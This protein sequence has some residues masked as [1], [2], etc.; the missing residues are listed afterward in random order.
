M[1]VILR[2]A[3]GHFIRVLVLVP[4]GCRRSQ[5][6]LS[7]IDSTGHNAVENSTLPHHQHPVPVPLEL[8]IHRPH[9]RRIAFG[10]QRREDGSVSANMAV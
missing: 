3:H 4:A 10:G 9:L 6:D 1:C 2:Q 5:G 8:V 7:R